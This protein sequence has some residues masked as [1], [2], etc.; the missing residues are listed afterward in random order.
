MRPRALCALR[1]QI[2]SL[3]QLPAQPLRAAIAPR[4][5][6]LRRR[7]RRRR[8][9]TRR[10]VGGESHSLSCP[11][12][13][14]TRRP[15]PSVLPNDRSSICRRVETSAIRASTARLCWT[16][17]MCER[18]DT[19]PRWCYLPTCADSLS[20]LLATSNLCEFGGTRPSRRLDPRS[21]RLPRSAAGCDPSSDMLR[22]AVTTI[23][24]RRMKGH[25]SCRVPLNERR[26]HRFSVTEAHNHG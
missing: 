18:R 22:T 1:G 19:R 5:R 21:L 8:A 14:M 13:R 4:A 26:Q 16:T 12:N 15:N 2:S 7:A 25:L 6:Y 10:D 20:R 3:Q 17:G 9:V 23:N 11:R 24:N